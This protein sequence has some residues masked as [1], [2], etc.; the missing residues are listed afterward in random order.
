MPSVAL[1]VCSSACPPADAAP[2]Q[3]LL[4]FKSHHLIRLLETLPGVRL[5]F[6]GE[7]RGPTQAALASDTRCR[8]RGP[9]ASLVYDQL[10][11]NLGVLL[12]A[13]TAVV[14]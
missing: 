3:N 14:H 10:A 9:Q 12:T 13:S 5:N 1:D 2:L 11:M 8:L 7:G 6:T 4:C